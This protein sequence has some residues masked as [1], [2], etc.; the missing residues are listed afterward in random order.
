LK[1]TDTK[2]LFVEHVYIVGNGSFFESNINS[3]SIGKYLGRSEPTKTAGDYFAWKVTNK[4]N[5]KTYFIDE[6]DGEIISQK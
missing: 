2:D 1:Q 4:K 5:N 6:I 3:N